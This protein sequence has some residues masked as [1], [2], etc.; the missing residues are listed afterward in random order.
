MFD[1]VVKSEVTFKTYELL[2]SMVRVS[3]EQKNRH[4]SSELWSTWA[5]GFNLGRRAGHTTSIF[6]YA[7]NHKDETIL[8]IFRNYKAMNNAIETYN[9]HPNVIYRTYDDIL[10]NIDN[11]RG[12]KVDR[13]FCDDI[14]GDL[15]VKLFGEILKSYFAPK[16]FVYLG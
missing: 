16:S 8:V 7:N 12:I 3:E 1:L 9:R 15:V 10:K 14:S 5:V 6:E 2:K 13:I 11:H 4:N